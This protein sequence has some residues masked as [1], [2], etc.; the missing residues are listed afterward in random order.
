MFK[1]GLVMLFLCSSLRVFGT[2]LPDD[3][4]VTLTLTTNE[5]KLLVTSTGRA[6]TH[7]IHRHKHKR[8]AKR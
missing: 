1:L 6:V 3:T 4:P 5:G 7:Y 2:V 8:K